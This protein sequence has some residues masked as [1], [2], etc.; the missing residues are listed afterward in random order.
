MEQ[1]PTIGYTGG[2]FAIPH[3]GHYNFFRLCKEYCEY[4]VVSLNTDEFIESHKGKAPEFNY[5]KR[6]EILSKCPYIDKIIPNIGDEDSKPAILNVMPD[7][8]IIGQD[9]LSKDYCKQMGF[10]PQWLTDHNISLMYLPH[11]DGISSTLIRKNLL[12]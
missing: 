1:K 8:I 2:S 9:W 3:F 5:E 11:T 4:L 10:T 6:V 12:K 7:V